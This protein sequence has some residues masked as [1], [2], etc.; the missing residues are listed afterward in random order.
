MIS[1]VQS[2]TLPHTGLLTVDFGS[3]EHAEPVGRLEMK[4][5]MVSSTFMYPGAYLSPGRRA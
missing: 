3:W 5:L 4:P 1:S 2:P